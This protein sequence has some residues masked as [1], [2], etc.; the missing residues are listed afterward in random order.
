MWA[1]FDWDEDG[2]TASATDPGTTG[3]LREAGHLG[4][5]FLGH[6]LGSFDA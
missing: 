2:W 5:P 3:I 6:H 1:I 4:R